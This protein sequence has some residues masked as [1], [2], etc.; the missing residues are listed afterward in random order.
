MIS[1]IDL[2]GVRVIDNMH[3]GDGDLRII[4]FNVCKLMQK[5]REY[6]FGKYF[7]PIIYKTLNI[8]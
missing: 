8:V 4:I 2:C 3:D 5:M 1:L 7:Y 6:Q